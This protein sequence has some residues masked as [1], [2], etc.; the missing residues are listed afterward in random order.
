MREIMGKQIYDSLGEIV[1]PEHT[2]LLVV[3]MQND[4]CK[5]GGYMD[6]L[7][8]AEKVADATKMIPKLVK[9]LD[10]A[11]KH[12]IFVVFIQN[13]YLPNGLSESPALV[14]AFGRVACERKALMWAGQWKVLGGR[15]RWSSCSP[16]LMSLLSGSIDLP[17]FTIRAWMRC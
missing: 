5:P 13:C 17:L 14:Y 9:F 3:D 4:Y 2:A 15:S 1:N 16:K 7:G 6:L 12:G 8:Y 11:R 10:R